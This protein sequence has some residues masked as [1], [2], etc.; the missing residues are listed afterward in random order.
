MKSFPNNLVEGH[1]KFKSGIFNQNVE[2]YEELADKGQYPKTMI[3]SCCDSRV[4]P[5]TIFNTGPGE[6]FVMRNIANLV[7]PFETGG[8]YHGVSAAIEYAALNLKVENIIILGHSKC[9]GISAA[10]DITKAVQTSAGFISKWMSILNEPVK[11][12]IDQ[13]GCN[14]SDE[15]HF[16]LEKDGV[17]HSL[18]NL[19]TFPCLKA[20]ED[21]GRIKLHGAHYD[22]RNG[23]LRIYDQ[24][25]NTFKLV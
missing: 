8:N 2:H 17:I 12:V 14:D 3:I 23:E 1:K 19:R 13:C 11:K 5:E 6:L 7:P 21:K 15:A 20:L 16:E 4:D 10:L 24:D 25:S 9:G 22:I 18:E